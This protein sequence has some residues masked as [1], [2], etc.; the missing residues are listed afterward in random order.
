MDEW[1]RAAIWSVS[2][3]LYRTVQ[4]QDPR[5]AAEISSAPVGSAPGFVFDRKRREPLTFGCFAGVR[6]WSFHSLSLSGWTAPVP[7][8]QVRLKLDA[9]D[10]VREAAFTADGRNIITAG[11]KGGRNAVWNRETGA[12]P[13]DAGRMR[14]GMLPLADASV[15]AGGDDKKQDGELLAP[16]ES[17]KGIRSARGRFFIG[18]CR[19]ET[20]VWDLSSRRKAL[21]MRNGD[22]TVLFAPDEKD[23]ITQA[24]QV[25][26]LDPAWYLRYACRMLREGDRRQAADFCLPVQG[27]LKAR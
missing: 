26:S 5:I 22:R 13:R 15:L 18:C 16:G 14:P 4:L 11:T 1:G 27:G 24:G 7:R 23:V 21:F 2:P 10:G 12:G 20:V 6:R 19:N 17:K 8:D 3:A 9:P 25:Y